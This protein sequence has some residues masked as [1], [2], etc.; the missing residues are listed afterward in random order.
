MKST[1]FALLTVLPLS[2]TAQTFEG[3]SVELQYQHY[4]DGDGFT[5]GTAEGYLDAAWNFGTFGTQIGLSYVGEIDSS[6]PFDYTQFRSIALHLTTDVSENLRLGAMIAANDAA[7]GIN[8]YAAEA[9]YLDG[10]LRVEARLGDNFDDVDPYRLAEV[11]GSYDINEALNLRAGAV[12]MD[13]GNSGFYHVARLGLGYDIADRTEIY[14]DYARHGNN[15]G[16]GSPTYNGSLWYVG[17]N[18]DLGN[19]GSDRLFNYQTKY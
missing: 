17:L 18:F 6:V 14:V 3:A 13:F 7:D 12:Y 16:G 19:K 5:V 10:P 15:F 8:L 4:D 1:L 11:L 2:A 9:L